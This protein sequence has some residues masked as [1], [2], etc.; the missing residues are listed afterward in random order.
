[1]GIDINSFGKEY[2]LAFETFQAGDRR[3]RLT[4]ANGEPAFKDSQEY[5]AI[6]GSPLLCPLDSGEWALV[7][8]NR[9]ARFTANGGA[10]AVYQAKRILIDN[11]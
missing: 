11:E 5:I 6:T 3:I 8:S 4:V 9:T 2:D 7:T 10:D 1:M